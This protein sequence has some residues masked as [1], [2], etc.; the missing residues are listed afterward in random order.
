MR[1]ASCGLITDASMLHARL[2]H[3]RQYKQAPV[4][5]RITVLAA[6]CALHSNAAA[7]FLHTLSSKCVAAGHVLHTVHGAVVSLLHVLQHIYVHGQY[8]AL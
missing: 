7:V 2:Q 5:G 3:L 6:S 8:G 1:Y 4:S